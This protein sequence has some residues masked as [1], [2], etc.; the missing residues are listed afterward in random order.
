METVLIIGAGHGAGQAVASLRQEGFGG[1]IILV[2]DEAYIPYHRPPLSKKFLEGELPLER[3]YLKPEKFYETQNVD[4]RLGERV[5]SINPADKTAELESGETISWDHLILATGSHVRRMDVPGHDLDGI[6]YLRTVDD[7]KAIQKDFDGG[8]KV[9][10]V[11]GGYIGLEIAAVA[12]KRGKDVTLFE[13]GDRILNRVVAPEMS[14]FYH[15]V[16]EEEGV[17]IH[18][19]TGIT[20]FEGDGHVQYA[21]TQDGEKFNAD[22]VVIGIGILPA[23]ELAEG[24]GIACENGVTVDA[25]CRTS[26]DN[27]Y[28]IGD[29]SNHP[30]P[31]YGRRLR[32]ESVPNAMGQAKITA[33]AI[34]GTL[35]EY[36][37]IPWFWSDQYNMKLQIAGLSEGYDQIVF[38]GDKAARKFAAFYLKEGKLI[39]MDGVNSPG[40]FMASKKLIMNGASPDAE[41]LADISVSMKDFM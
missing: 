5:A 39:S 12:R 28:A 29:C 6:H 25:H 11:G 19:N 20:A 18:L 34:C 3:L 41:K 33:K 8:Q 35:E 7:V 16:H 14:A 38:R 10:I 15:G 24:A 1:R 31:L 23:I 37:E 32:L 26:A 2:G 13:M 21:V 30:S 17:V 4:M 40:E 9:V 36:N 27:I 22:L